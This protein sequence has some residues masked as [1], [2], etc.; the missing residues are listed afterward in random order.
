MRFQCKRCTDYDLCSLCY[1]A[2]KH[3]LTHPFQRFDSASAQ[4]MELPIR[5]NATKCYLRGIF[6]GAIVVR[7]HDWEWGVQDG[8]EGKTGRVMDI[9]GWDN[10]SARSV[11]NVKWSSGSINVYR[12]GHKGKCD[13]KFI[14]EAS[15]GYY[16]RDHIPI[17]GEQHE[18]PVTIRPVTINNKSVNTQF[19]VGDKVLVNVTVEELKALQQGHGG[20]NQRMA[21]VS[22]YFCKIM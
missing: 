18:V 15:G 14:Q 1:H 17:L 11:V 6:V 12:L 5:K 2:D 3:D 20:W 4:G 7:G 8:G 10:E 21:E 13:L 16:Y 9:Q 19:S 22:N